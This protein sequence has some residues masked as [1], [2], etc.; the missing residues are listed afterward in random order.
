MK[1]QVFKQIVIKLKRKFEIA[2]IFNQYNIVFD[3]LIN[4][5]NTKFLNKPKLINKRLSNI[6]KSKNILID[7]RL[8]V[9]KN[10]LNKDNKG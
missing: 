6:F 2:I 10:F 9:K 8:D 4:N 1:K 3:D 7:F 5:L